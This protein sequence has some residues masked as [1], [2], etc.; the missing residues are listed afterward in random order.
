MAVVWPRC[1]ATLMYRDTTLVSFRR[2]FEEDEV[3]IRVWAARLANTTELPI[4]VMHTYAGAR[5]LL[6]SVDAEFPGRLHYWPVNIVH[7]GFWGKWPWYRF[8]HTKL[9]AWAL[10]CR[11]V[12]FLDYD[13]IPLRNLDSVF[14]Q[15]GE[16]SPLCACEDHV[17]PHKVGLRLPNAGMLVLRT[18]HSAHQFLLQEAETEARTSKTRYHAEQGFLNSHF[19]SW[20]SMSD[21]YNI[22]QYHTRS[23][24]RKNNM[25]ESGAIA[26]LL[27]SPASFFLHQKLKEMPRSLVEFLGFADAWHEVRRIH[28]RCFIG[29]SPVTIRIPVVYLHGFERRLT[30]S[31]AYACFLHDVVGYIHDVK[32]AQVTNTSDG[33]VMNARLTA[34]THGSTKRIIGS[35]RNG[36]KIDIA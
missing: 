12:A 9:H 24:A 20:R 5:V 10:P 19:P 17:T 29:A 21:G 36:E 11:Q 13:G 27:Q 26:A 18:N 32:L 3:M 25:S 1:Y 31:D 7:G 34:G 33:V 16:S 23:Y 6:Q 35:G 30:G 4:F 8:V 14:D 22:N 2:A 15:C 28:I